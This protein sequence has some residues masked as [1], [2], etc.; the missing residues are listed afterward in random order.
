MKAAVLVASILLAACGHS[1]PGPACPQIVD[2]ILDVSKQGLTGH[3]TLELGNRKV[4]IADCERRH[5]S[6]P[7]RRCIMAA[8]SLADLSSCRDLEPAAPAP[9]VPAATGSGL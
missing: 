9:A 4:M 3:G 2:H 7:A 1:D 6:K 8:K 5:M